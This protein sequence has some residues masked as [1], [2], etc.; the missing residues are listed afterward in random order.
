MSIDA[1][2]S[3]RDCLASDLDLI[4]FF[5]VNYQADAKYLIGYERSNNAKD[6]PFISLVTS[7]TDVGDPS[8]DRLLIS[9]L[10]GINNAGKTDDDI[11][12][13]VLH[14][15]QVV[16]LILKRIST[17]NIDGKLVWLGHARI[18]TDLQ[19]RHP[20]YE[21]ELILPMLWRDFN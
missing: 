19:K 20:F 4:D 5:Q 1:M 8:G 12:N 16:R 14:T 21:A 7:L 18:E 6:Y 15:E 10:V 11:Y 2:R 9:V 3:L 13:G 17:G